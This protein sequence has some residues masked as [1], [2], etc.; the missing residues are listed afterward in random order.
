MRADSRTTLQHTRCLEGL[1][2]GLEKVLYFSV[3]FHQ[4]L[5]TLVYFTTASCELVAGMLRLRVVTV[6]LNINHFVLSEHMKTMTSSKDSDSRK[7]DRGLQG[8]FE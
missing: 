4:I 8:I 3:V 6:V 5:P 1:I 2:F 7:H